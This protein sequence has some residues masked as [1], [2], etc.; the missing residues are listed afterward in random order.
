MNNFYTHLNEQLL[1][2]M[3]EIGRFDGFKIMVYGSEGPVPH[4]HVENKEEGVSC[5]VRI[6]CAEY[7][8]HGKH[9]DTLERKNVKKLST[10]LSS[11]HKFFGKH[12]YNNW[13]IICVY[14]NDN[15]PEYTLDIEST[16][17][18]EYSNL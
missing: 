12:G 3:A 15:N 16:R 10:F 11:P 14:W 8:Q 5:C 1:L 6:D 18:P 9:K 7:F 2:E 13:Q 17:M 4:F